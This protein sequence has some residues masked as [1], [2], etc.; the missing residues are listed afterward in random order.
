MKK[1]DLILLLILVL[2]FLPFFISDNIY[3]AYK[4]FNAEHA[5]IM[6]FIK[7]AVLATYGEVIGARIR[8]GKYNMDGFGILPRAIIWG[9]LGLTIKAAFTLFSAG[10]PVILTYLGMQGTKAIMASPISGSKLLIAFSISLTMNLTFS[11]VLMTF[12]KITDLHI[13]KYN[14]SLSC[15][16]HPINFGKTLQG[17]DWDMHWGFVLKK[18]IPFF[19]I[20][21]HTIT[22]LLPVDFQILFAA[23]LGIALGII[24]AF[25][26]ATKTVKK[27]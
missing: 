8:T 27:Q 26:G 17:I 5:Y 25:A 24:L 1:Q 18:S 19:W 11:P 12:H 16:L 15:F 13:I 23:M 7:F 14:G 10:A 3:S 9:F 6:S 21:A 2:L 20:P 4:V 22:F